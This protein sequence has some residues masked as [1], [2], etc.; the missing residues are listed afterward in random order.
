M[1]SPKREEAKFIEKINLRKG[2]LKGP[3]E[4]LNEKKNS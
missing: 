4:K 1:K 2:I 3:E